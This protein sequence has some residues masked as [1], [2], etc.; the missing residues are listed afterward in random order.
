MLVN[1]LA[2]SI[3]CASSLPTPRTLEMPR[4][5]ANP[6]VDSLH[7]SKVAP[8]FDAFKS[9]LCTTTPCRRASRTSECGDQKPIGCAFNNAA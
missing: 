4:R 3:A 7:G 5:N 1:G 6:P 8:A 2:A 9:G